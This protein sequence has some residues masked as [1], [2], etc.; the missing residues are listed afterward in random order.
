[1][2]KVFE[3]AVEVLYGCG[4][5]VVVT[6]MGKS[7]LVARKIAATLSSTGT[8][9]LFLHPSI[10]VSSVYLMSQMLAVPAKY[11]AL[12]TS[13]IYASDPFQLLPFLLL[14]HFA[15]PFSA[16]PRFLACMFLNKT[17]CLVS[18]C[19]QGSL[20]HRS[21]KPAPGRLYPDRYQELWQRIPAA[22]WLALPNL[23]S[24]DPSRSPSPPVQ[25]SP[26]RGYRAK[27]H[28][29]VL[30]LSQAES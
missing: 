4:G 10:G 16:L 15:I 1:M 25:E 29:L 26:G 13:R 23:R 18:T 3:Q 11:P 28:H 5:R 2:A 21:A 8:P 19:D 6:G 24:Y 14:V 7:G 22:R 20:K 30:R 17:S 27:P 9:A 12:G